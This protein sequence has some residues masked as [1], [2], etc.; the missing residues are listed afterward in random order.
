[1]KFTFLLFLLSTA[2]AFGTVYSQNTKL[3]LNLQNVSIVDVLKTI[4]N[5]S[6]FRFLYNDDLISKGKNIDV[7]ITNKKIEDIL[8]YIFIQTEN[9]YSILENNLI[10]IRP[11]STTFQQ[12]KEIKGTVTSKNGETLVGATVTV[13]G[14]LEGTVTDIDGNYKLI[15]SSENPVLVFS[16]I[17][18]KSLE[19]PLNGKS[20]LD[21]KLDAD[22]VGLDEVV[23]VGYGTVK[24]SDITGSVASVTSKDLTIYPTGDAIQALQ[25]MAAGVQVQSTNGEPGSG[26]NISIRGNTS[27]NASSEPLIVVDGFPGATM[28]PPEDIESMEI[29][30]DASSTAIYGSRGANGVVL[31][32]TKSGKKG[33]LKIDINTSYSFQKEIGRN[34]VLNATDFATYIN[35]IDPDFYN[36]PS[37]YGLGTNWQDVIYRNGAL[38]NHQ[39]SVSG[40]SDAITYYLSGSYQGH[41]GVIIGSEHK[42]YSFTSNIQAQVLDWVNVGVN[43]FARR[44]NLDGVKSQT[45]GYYS[46]SV[47]DLAYKFSPTSGIYNEDGSYTLTDRGVPADNPYALAKEVKQEKI[48]DLIQGNFFAELDLWKNL[49]FKTT[50]GVNSSSSRNGV[51]YPSTTE[52]GGSSNGEASL[53]YYKHLDLASENYFTYSAT[54]N[55][56]HDLSVMAGY[57]YQSYANEGMYIEGATGFPTDAFSF[58]NLGAATGSPTYDS[59]LRE[60]ELSSFYGRLNYGFKSK[61]LFTF[62]VRYDGSSVFAKNNKYAFF[63]SGAFAWDVK[64][65]EFMSTVKDISQLKLRISYGI[66]GNQAIEAYQ[67]LATLTDVYAS[68]RGGVLSAI[69]P[70]TISNPNLSWESTE[71]VN[72]GL[73]LGLFESR[74]NVTADYYKMIT[75]DLLFDVPV[76]AF[77]GFTTQLQNIGKVQNSGFEFSVGAKILTNK[78]KWNSSANISAN[79]NKV[80]KLVENE[81]EGNDIY[82]SSAPLEGASGIKTQILREGLPVGSFFGYLY[83]GVQQADDLLLENAEGVGGE[84][85]VDLTPD[86]ILSDDDRTIIGDPHPDFIWGWN[87]NLQYGNFEL[88][89]FIQGSYGADMLNYTRMELG[90]LN[91]RNNASLD[92][93]DRWTPAN[94]DTNI[95]RANANRSYEFSDRW[96]EDASYIRLKN[97]SLGYNFDKSLIQKM[98]FRSAR[99]YVSAQNLL[100]LTKYKG[101]DPEVAYKTSNTNL[102]L[103]Y[104][105]YPNTKSI[106]VGLNLGF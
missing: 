70:G 13:K 76:P 36:T 65:E 5:Q 55:D 67:S 78:L 85:F 29:L 22:Y 32:T 21:I 38:Q 90:I 82:Y 28:P 87:N 19:I 27:I 42:R 7:D 6:E 60:S 71:Q 14:T 75:S 31:I 61:Y 41:E 25:G 1:M 77:S 54:F 106:T 66:T 81:T 51:F 53:S 43:I 84:M 47:P 105:S 18:F 73:D 100:T 56:I 15:V 72:F 103:D 26:Y 62:N 88:N 4:E 17:G 12:S 44:T 74:I 9:T 33:I 3:S 86:G 64:D 83:N 94:T 95:P 40:G 50:F 91:G 35:E 49:K 2:Q 58:W 69:K 23:V 63:P 68:D 98:K 20:I 93:L 34:E 48:S 99:I 16:F 59:S 57:S 79:R 92:A 8:D 102:G 46:P 24:K 89:L 104:A 97:I 45:G 96:V 30:K 39:L 10:V 52:R 37:S 80:L 11:G 101:V